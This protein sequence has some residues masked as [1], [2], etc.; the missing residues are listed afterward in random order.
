MNPKIALKKI[1]SFTMAVALA[2]AFSF[3]FTAV[4]SY[5]YNTTA[6]IR[7][8]Y[9]IPA[10]LSGKTVILHTNDVHGAIGRYAYVASVKENIEKRG[11]EVIL[12]DAGDFS[13]GTPYVSTTNGLDA[14][15]SMNAAGYDIVTLGNHEFDYGYL[16][17]I[18]NLKVAKFKAICADVLDENGNTIIAPNTIY[19]TK[20]GMK[21]GFFGM[22]TPETQTKANPALIKGIK[23]LSKGELYPCAQSQI[24]SLKAQGSDLVI[25]LS[26]MGVDD[27]S[28]PDGHRSVDLYSKTKG[29]DIMIDG[30][31]HTIMTAGNKNE[32]IT[33]TGTKIQHIGVIVIDNATKAIEDRYLITLDG[34]QKEVITDAV[35]TSIIKRVDKEY[36]VTFAKSEVKLNGDRDPGNRTEE[37]NLGDLITD[38]MIY[39]VTKTSGAITVDPSHIVAVTNGGGIRAEIKAG[40]VTKNDIN[41]VLPFGNTVAVVYITGAELLEALEASTYCTPKAIGG[42]PQTA[43]IKFTVDTTKPFAKGPAYP[44]STYYKPAKINRVTIE[45]ING[46]PFSATDTYAVVTNDFCMAGGDTYYVFENA[47]SEFNTGIPLDEAVVDYV[48]NEL[49]GT[50]TAAKYGSPRGDQT[51]L[52]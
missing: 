30:H 31:S 34:L 7:T 51:I 8:I 19:T 17:L 24:D 13:Q 37:T 11:A 22:E 43:G 35:V 46:Q 32:P 50:I 5:A 44:D 26:H 48:K 36:G 12:V 6:D 39:S 1:L 2:L 4:N 38:A 47:S 25:C 45:S 29:I 40:D 42:Y 21:I 3:N 41:T 49:H 27:E 14:I 52:K 23:F 28:A 33:S 16:Q 15:T 10:D 20:S 18:S 9:D